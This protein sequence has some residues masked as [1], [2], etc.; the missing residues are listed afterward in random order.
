MIKIEKQQY[1]YSG[2]TDLVYIVNYDELVVYINKIINTIN[3]RIS[4]DDINS[5]YFI[6]NNYCPF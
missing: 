3:N 1:D 5:G 2:L 6:L 4:I